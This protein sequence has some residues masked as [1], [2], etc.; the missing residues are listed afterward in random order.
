MRHDGHFLTVLRM[1]PNRRINRTVIGRH[2][3]HHQRQIST[4][5]LTRFE[6]SRQLSMTAVVF[7]HEYET[8]RIF[9]QAVHN[10]RALFAADAR[11]RVTGRRTT[12]KRMTRKR[13][14]EGRFRSAS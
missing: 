6:L 10:T 14:T 12:R 7:R 11:K 13:M 8:R 9:I 5:Y 4:L 2:T 1:T 3:S